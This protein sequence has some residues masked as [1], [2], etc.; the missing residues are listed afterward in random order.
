MRRSVRPIT[1]LLGTRYRAVA[2][3]AAPGERRR[4]LTRTFDTTDEALAWI[5]S[6]SP[7]PVTTLDR[8]RA[9]A[10]VDDAGCW[11]WQGSTNG[12]YG[13][14]SVDGVLALAHRAAWAAVH[15]PI[16]SGLEIDH[17]CRVMLCCNPDHLEPVTHEENMRRRRSSLTASR[18]LTVVH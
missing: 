3:V 8:I 14:L 10:I 1:T 9:R 11:L 12:Y 7:R 2:D 6:V 13:H 17:L 16:P 5:E 15:G 4:Q 18:S